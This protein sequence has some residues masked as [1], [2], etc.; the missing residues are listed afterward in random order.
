MSAAIFEPLSATPAAIPEPPKVIA[1]FANRS[2][3]E[4]F[5]RARNR[6]REE[7]EKS[8]DPQ[9]KAKLEDTANQLHA[10]MQVEKFRADF[11]DAIANGEDW[12]IPLQ[13]SQDWLK[14]A[15]R[16]S[17]FPEPQWWV[18]VKAKTE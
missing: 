4:V 16:D 14:L 17:R 5:K 8:T 10:R 3:S 12:R 1:M 6:H 15:R 11:F 7:A 18:D 2:A 9:E 13:A